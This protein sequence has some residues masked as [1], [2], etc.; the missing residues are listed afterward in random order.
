MMA[1]KR[2]RLTARVSSSSPTAIKPVLEKAVGKTS[3]KEGND[4]FLVEARMEGE[5]AKD[6]NRS[7]LSALRRVEKRTRLRAE[8][9]SDD[10][11]T[12]RY[13]DYVLKKTTKAGPSP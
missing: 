4:E 13:F 9:T 11:T 12:E 2:F 7:L 6:L 5:S 1:T 10:G 8:W 3:V